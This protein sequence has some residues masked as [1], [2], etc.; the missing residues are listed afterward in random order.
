M[1]SLIFHYILFDP[2]NNEIIG[3]L[4]T[5]CLSA[6]NFIIPSVKINECLF[7]FEEEVIEETKYDDARVT[8]AT[9]NE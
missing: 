7:K 5:I 1:G 4:L 2:S 3:D 8:F 9:V 6:I